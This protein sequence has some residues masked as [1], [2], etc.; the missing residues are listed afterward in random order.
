M[1]IAAD[2]C[3][4]QIRTAAGAQLDFSTATDDPDRLV[5]V[6]Q[7]TSRLNTGFE[8]A[9]FSLA[10]DR[11]KR[12][13]DLDLLQEVVIDGADGGRQ[14]EGF[15]SAIAP[16]SGQGLKVLA[17]GHFATLKDKRAIP[18]LFRDRDLTHWQS[19]TSANKVANGLASYRVADPT[20]DAQGVRLALS[21]PPWT[22]NG[23]P[24]SNA[25]Y[26]APA[27]DLIG[28]IHFG[29]ERGV[30]AIHLSA[31]YDWRLYGCTDDVGGGAISTGNLRAAGPGSGTFTLSVP[32]RFAIAQLQYNLA[33]A[34]A[35][36]NDRS[37]NWTEL[38]VEGTHGLTSLTPST[39]LKYLLATHAPGLRFD[40]DSIA[41]HPY[42]FGHLFHEG[43]DLTMWIAELNKVANWQFGVWDDKRFHYGPAPDLRAPDWIL[44]EDEGATLDTDS[45]AVSEDWPI[46][47]VEVCF[48][49]VLTGFEE[50]VGPDDDYRL[51]S[52]DDENACNKED[53]QRWGRIDVSEPCTREDAIQIGAVWFAEQ[54][55]P[56]RTGSGTATGTV[57]SANGQVV[58][59]GVMRAGDV[60]RYEHESLGRQLTSM[61]Y[62]PRGQQASF[63]FESGAATYAAFLERLGIAIALL[64][65]TRRKR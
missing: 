13:D 60:V 55:V 58:P 43:Q 38:T 49:D 29:W 9:E 20:I 42:E 65:M 57:R 33:Y 21:D 35:D 6:E 61:T 22:T 32:K 46:S 27:G 34:T 1:T 17:T 45:N 24:L 26:V 50:V 47:G 44:S 64:R 36:T 51:R 15:I 14:F 48:N 5:T 11:H 41:E 62:Q 23:K 2:D 63:E 30:E 19:P 40:D 37:V 10:R 12:Y 18:G 16:E 56:G 3:S 54:L 59:V 28:K 31:D 52:D 53:R 25:L 7:V 8:S 39:V 4:V